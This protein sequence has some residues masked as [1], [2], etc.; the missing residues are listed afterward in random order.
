MKD[1]KII[2]KLEKCR[3]LRGLPKNL[4]HRTFY[5]FGRFLQEMVDFLVFGVL[6]YE[7]DLKNFQMSLNR[8]KLNAEDFNTYVDLFLEYWK[9]F[10][11]WNE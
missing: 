11:R 10:E 4:S 5:E 1:E 2:K 9:N 6:S 3:R 7:K 8:E